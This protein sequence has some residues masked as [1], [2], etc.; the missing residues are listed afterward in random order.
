MAGS[1]RWASLVL[2]LSPIVVSAQE[3]EATLKNGAHDLKNEVVRVPV[4]WPGKNAGLATDGP[5]A[6]TVNGTKLVG[7]LVEP[8]FVTETIKPTTGHVRKDLIVVVPSVK[9]NETLKVAVDPNSKADASAGFSWKDVPGD[10]SE[11]S[12]RDSSG[13]T[14]PVLRYMCKTYDTSS[15]DARNK[16]YK[17]F[18]H[19]YDPEG[20][21]YVTNGGHNDP[22]QTEK[23]LLYPHHRGLFFAF[24]K[25]TYDGK[26]ADI[27]HCTKGTH[28]AHNKTIF[29]TGGPVAADQRVL[30]DWVGQKGDVFAQ[31]ERQMT[32]Y[33]VP[34][35]TLVEFATR[36]KPLVDKVK[37]DGDPQHSGF[38]FRA[39]NEVSKNNKQTYYLRPDGKGELGATR[40]WDP[41]TKKGPIN[42]PWDVMSFVLGGKRYSVE[43]IDSPANP[44]EKRYSERDYGRFGCYF[45][46]TLTP[47][48]PLLLNHRIWLQDGEMSAD[49]AIALREGF[50]DGPKVQ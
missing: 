9:A 38:H 27:W 42:L 49:Q 43:Y 35:G 45:E 1:F 46:Y 44:G 18:H 34:G 16:T 3:I 30:I 31:E 15:P 26:E 32:V 21:R 28:S 10:Y 37:L 33:K 29:E 14:I 40:N 20:T 13:K 41:K 24:N 17:V 6:C 25:I 47:D 4:Q 39:A 48:H 19:L 8:S 11:A 22:H 50:V 23:D 12:Y 5:V 7:Q 36:L 2:L